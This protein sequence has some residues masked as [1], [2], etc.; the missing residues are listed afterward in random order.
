MELPDDTTDLGE[1]GSGN[2]LL[3]L[4]VPG[5]WTAL[6]WFW[7]DLVVISLEGWFAAAVL[8]LLALEPCLE[9]S[10]AD[11]ALV[12]EVLCALK[13][14]VESGKFFRRCNWRS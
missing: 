9:G 2:K 11:D 12:L 8:V 13:H 4:D 7:N 5:V 14:R 10:V 1:L 6:K 3:L